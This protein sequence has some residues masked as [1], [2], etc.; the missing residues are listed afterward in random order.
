MTEPLAEILARL[1]QHAVPDR[2]AAVGGM[3]RFQ[4]TS[5][6]GRTVETAAVRFDSGTARRSTASRT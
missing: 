6:K 5:T 2:L 1:P 3:V 4:T